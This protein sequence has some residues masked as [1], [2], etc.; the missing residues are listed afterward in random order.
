MS[1]LVTGSDLVEVTLEILDGSA[2]PRNVNCNNGD[3]VGK[4]SCHSSDFFKYNVMCVYWRWREK[5]KKKEKKRERE[6]AEK[7]K[8]SHGDG[9]SFSLS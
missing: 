1:L 2:Q 6:S 8:E 9:L 5:E 4:S 3:D 7:N